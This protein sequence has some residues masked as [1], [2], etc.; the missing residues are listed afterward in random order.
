MLRVSIFIRIIYL[1]EILLRYYV[2]GGRIEIWYRIEQAWVYN[3][4]IIRVSLKSLERKD[5]TI[6]SE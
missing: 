3:I 5:V 2:I 6:E 1:S 4:I